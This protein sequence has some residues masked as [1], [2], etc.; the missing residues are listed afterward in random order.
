MIEWSSVE[1]KVASKVENVKTR[2]V[3]RLT[4]KLS[5]AQAKKLVNRVKKLRFVFSNES[6]FLESEV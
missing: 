1:A 2:G 5:Q 3:N 6:S 4:L